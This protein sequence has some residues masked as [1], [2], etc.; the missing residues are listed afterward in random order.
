MASLSVRR[1]TALFA[2][3]TM[4]LGAAFV[5][6][7]PASA[8]PAASITWTARSA[9]AN[10]WNSVTYG[11]GTFVAVLSGGPNRVMTS[12]DGITW[13]ARSATSA[14]AWS[15]VTYG[16]G[17]F[18]AVSLEGGIMSSTD[19]TTWT[20]RTPPQAGRS[21]NSV[22]YG[23]GTFVAVAS[24]EAALGAMTSPDGTTWTARTTPIDAW[25]S[26][27]YGGSTFVATGWSG[28]VMT[29]PD[30]A[31]WTTR[32]AAETNQWWSVTYGNGTFVAVASGG[33][34]QVMTSPDGISWTAQAAAGNNS[35]WS[36]TYGNGTFVAVATNGTNQVMTSPDGISWTAQ[37]A[38][39][40]SGWYSVT[41]GGGTFVAVAYSGSNR[42]MTGATASPPSAPTALVATPGNGTASIAF[43][44]GADGGSAITK[45]Q[46]QLGSGSWTDAA[47][48]TSPITVT[49]LINYADTSIKV[50]AYNA[51]GPGPEST[52]IVVRTKLG[53]PTLTAAYSASSSASPN[54]GILAAFTGVNPAGATMVSYR[55]YAYAA[56]TNTPVSSCLVNARTRN[57]F[58]LGL[59]N[60][61]TYDVRVVGYLTLTGS[62]L[63]TRSTNES[64]TRAVKV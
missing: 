27:A 47:G 8:A 63:I 46:Y 34:H 11:N 48:T 36:V 14:Q 49:G 3:L 22:T 32:T 38:A 35:W 52:A 59:T 43:T 5:S 7:Q 61:V 4:L 41:Y 44:P 45:Y 19:G 39:A 18:V 53:A 42:V 55:A 13:T 10:Q 60:G 54:R 15:S 24:D 9:V 29:S 31:T 26:V 28:G 50:R 2:A 23:N 30:G 12:P 17:T 51:A 6:V 56:G 62:P 21:W 37:A 64:A 40:V 16:G 33:T 25:L 58:I 57:C 1:F 20:S